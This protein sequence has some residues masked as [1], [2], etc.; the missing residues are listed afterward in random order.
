MAGQYVSSGA[1]IGSIIPGVG[2]AIGTAAGGILEIVT[3]LFHGQIKGADFPQRRQALSGWL[4]QNA[5]NNSDYVDVNYL[6][7]LLY[8]DTG[9][10]NDVQQ[11]LAQIA[12]TI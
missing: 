4:T 6:Q 8:E 3:S 2:T 5:L 10:Q 12:R 11:Y 9:W 1:A 7:V